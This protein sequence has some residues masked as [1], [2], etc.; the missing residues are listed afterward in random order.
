M[1]TI[2]KIQQRMNIL[3]GIRLRVD[4]VTT[5]AQPTGFS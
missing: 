2:E 1:N 3:A 4:Q 5:I